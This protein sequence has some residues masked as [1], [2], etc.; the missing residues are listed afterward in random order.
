MGVVRT[1]TMTAPVGLLV[2]VQDVV[3]VVVAVQEGEEE[4]RR[5]HHLLPPGHFL[6][7]KIYWTRIFSLVGPF[8]LS[9]LQGLTL[10]S[11]DDDPPPPPRR[12]DPPPKLN[13]APKTRKAPAPPKPPKTTTTA[14]PAV[15]PPPLA[16]V[17]STSSV[18]YCECGYP[19][20]ETSVILA[21]GPPCKRWGCGNLGKC[22]FFQVDRN[23]VPVPLI[24]QKRPSS[25]QVGRFTSC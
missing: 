13:P 17:P 22:E 4:V 9:A 23:P 24:P 6:P 15:R 3:A 8:L 14:K 11:T 18:P 5:P 10:W 16:P 21:R 19:A 12:P 20:L 1:A 2:A 25:E 7:Q